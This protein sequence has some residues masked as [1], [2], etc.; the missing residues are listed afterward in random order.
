MSDNVK[1][2]YDEDKAKM[3]L[4]QGMPLMNDD[5]SKW[6]LDVEPFLN[7]IYHELLGKVFIDGLWV[8][9]PK[10]PK[11]LNELGA[12]E[13]C[14][15]ISA[16]VSIHQQLSDLEDQDIVEIA[17]MAAEIFADKLEDN[18]DLWGANPSTSSLTS[19]AQKLYDSLYI[20]LRIAR[21]GGMQRHREHV[22]NPYIRDSYRPQPEAEWGGQQ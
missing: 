17:S 20:F 10:K 19:I 6:E 3:D 16:R 7:R 21:K 4:A 2:W 12:S 15:E 1:K 18:W 14:N 8:E 11:L 5:N 13:F 22:K 9:H